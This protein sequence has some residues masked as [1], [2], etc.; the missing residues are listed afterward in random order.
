MLCGISLAEQECD[1]VYLAPSLK[2]TLGSLW[3]RRQASFRF[4]SHEREA[5]R[6]ELCTDPMIKPQALS[7]GSE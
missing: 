3:T 1:A 4:S 7:Q 6:T 2:K 5:N